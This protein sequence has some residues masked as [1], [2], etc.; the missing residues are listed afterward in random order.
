VSDIVSVVQTKNR[1]LTDGESQVVS[2][3]KQKG[4][5]LFKMTEVQSCLVC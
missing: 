4:G 1:K 5:C 2:H 3:R